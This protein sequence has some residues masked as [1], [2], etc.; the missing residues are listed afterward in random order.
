MYIFPGIKQLPFENE[1]L[2][3]E[4]CCKLATKKNGNATTRKRHPRMIY[5]FAASF[6]ASFEN[7]IDNFEFER[8]NS[9]VYNRLKQ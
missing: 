4:Q 6:G 8:S 5:D 7:S 9:I 1:T 2:H 3:S